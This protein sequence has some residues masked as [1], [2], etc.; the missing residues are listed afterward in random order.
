MKPGIHCVRT[1]WIRGFM[2]FRLVRRIQTMMLM[3]PVCPGS[4]FLGHAAR[5]RATSY[6]AYGAGGTCGAG[7]EQTGG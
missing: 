6:R 2:T 5:P 4:G 3:V 7:R 1:H